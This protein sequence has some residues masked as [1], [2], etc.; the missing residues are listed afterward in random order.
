[1]KNTILLCTSAFLGLTGLAGA[2]EFTGG[3]ISLDYSTFTGDLD[4]ANKL[5]LSGSAELA[6]GRNFSL[7]GDLAYN[8]FGAT[9]ADGSAFTLHAI[10]HLSPSASVGLFYGQ[11]SIEGGSEDYVGLE[12]GAGFGAFTTEAYATSA[13]SEVLWGLSGDYAVNEAFKLGAGFDTVNIEGIDLTRYGLTG[14]V[15]VTDQMLLN[16]TIGSARVES[17]GS[18]TYVAIGAEFRFGNDRGTTFDSRHISKVL[19]GL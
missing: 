10:A 19:P 17:V 15:K 7:Q 11:E 3:Q 6:L 5:T 18:E 1:M 13:S 14:E 8:S 9:D 12:F 2:Q 4:E 16:A